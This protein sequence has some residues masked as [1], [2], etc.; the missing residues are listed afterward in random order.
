[1]HVQLF[2]L[3]KMLSVVAIGF[4]YLQIWIMIQDNIIIHFPLTLPHRTF[5]IAVYLDS[6]FVP[7]GKVILHDLDTR[8]Y[9]SK[10]IKDKNNYVIYK[11]SK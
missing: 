7:R 4:F 10:H 11:Q 3:N 8:N 6:G 1:M 2:G 9:E 5:A